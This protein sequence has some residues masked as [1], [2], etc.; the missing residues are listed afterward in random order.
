MERNHTASSK[1]TTSNISDEGIQNF[2][3]SNVSSSD[4]QQLQGFMNRI[5]NEWRENSSK[6][7]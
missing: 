7:R 1:L 4:F 3:S 6:I 5:E 2:N